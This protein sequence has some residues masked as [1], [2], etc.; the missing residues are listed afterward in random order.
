M[1]GCVQMYKS[2]ERGFRMIS[3]EKKRLI[4]WT[5]IDLLYDVG[6]LV[7][8]DS[9]Y[10]EEIHEIT[11]AFLLCPESIEITHDMLSP[12]AKMCLQKILFIFHI[13]KGIAGLNIHYLNL[14]Y[15][16]FMTLKNVALFCYR[17]LHGLVLQLYLQLE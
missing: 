12:F 6:Y 2:P 5:R 3:I 7:E 8:C 11:K 1:H 14:N 17:G 13:S 10:P 4:D 15:S 9:Y 16:I